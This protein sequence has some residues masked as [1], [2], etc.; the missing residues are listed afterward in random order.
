MK[1]TQFPTKQLPFDLLNEDTVEDAGLTMRL[2]ETQLMARDFGR[3]LGIN[4]N[5]PW[6]NARA[7]YTNPKRN[8][9]I[10][11]YVQYGKS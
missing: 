7:E 5:E 3:R 11:D 1:V 4:Y 8:G 2:R 10:P 6:Y 9:E